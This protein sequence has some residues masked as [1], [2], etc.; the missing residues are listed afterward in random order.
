MSAPGPIAYVNTYRSMPVPT[1]YGV[2]FIDCDWTVA[3]KTIP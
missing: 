2:E 3:G 1:E